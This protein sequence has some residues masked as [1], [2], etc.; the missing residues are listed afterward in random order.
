MT[1]VSSACALPYDFGS[2]ITERISYKQIYWGKKRKEKKRKKR[3]GER[4]GREKNQPETKQETQDMKFH[5]HLIRSQQDWDPGSPPTPV[6]LSETSPC[7]ET[8]EQISLGV[9]HLV[10]LI[11]HENH[12]R[13]PSSRLIYIHK[14]SKSK[15]EK[16]SAI[17]LHP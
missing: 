2:R 12:I 1:E 17:S 10:R 14:L 15:T 11:G 9:N 7:L 5:W 6:S 8:K 16:L 3:G 4:R 13:Q